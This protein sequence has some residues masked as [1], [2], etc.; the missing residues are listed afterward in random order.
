MG[1][2][3][4]CISSI[5]ILVKFA[6]RTLMWCTC[7]PHFSYNPS[8]NGYI[9]YYRKKSLCLSAINVNGNFFTSAYHLA[10]V[11]LSRWSRCV[12]YPY[13]MLINNLQ[14]PISEAVMKNRLTRRVVDVLK[15]DAPN[16]ILFLFTG[17]ANMQILLRFNLLHLAKPTYY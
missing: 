7:L 11:D 14:S 15:N 9:Q 8:W 10:E 2:A 13:R 1:V 3:D 4:L 17:D 16:P 6:S 12:L 5:S